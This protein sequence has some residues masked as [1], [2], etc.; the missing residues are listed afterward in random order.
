MVLPKFGI[1]GS[2]VEGR[3]C[4]CEEGKNGPLPLFHIFRPKRGLPGFLHAGAVGSDNGRSLLMIDR[5]P[6]HGDLVN[7]AIR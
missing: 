4:G 7:T 6:R 2:V 1:I 3:M 5:A